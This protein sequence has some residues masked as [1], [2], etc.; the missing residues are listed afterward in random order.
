MRAGLARALGDCG[1]YAPGM[2]YLE[3]ALLTDQLPTNRGLN[4]T[5]SSQHLPREASHECSTV[6]LPKCSRLADTRA[7]FREA[8]R[9]ERSTSSVSW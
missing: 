8:A 2:G 4:Q 9:G 5:C 1:G 3:N 6:I 7:A